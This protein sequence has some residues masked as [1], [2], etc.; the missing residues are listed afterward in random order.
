MNQVK[1]PWSVNILAES[2][3]IEL[4]KIDRNFYDS[5][6]KYYT[7]EIE[8]LYNKYIFL[9]NLDISLTNTCFFCIKFYNIS[10]K[11]LQMD[12]LENK[13]MLVRVLDNYKNM[14]NN[15][16]RIAI[17]DIENNDK[18][19]LYIKKYLEDNINY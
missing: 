3:A 10:V 16:I 19:F 8:R 4:S 14:D 11:K 9:N 15:S 7:S 12:L 1:K 17:K 6:K 18:I 13:N 2:I 5:T